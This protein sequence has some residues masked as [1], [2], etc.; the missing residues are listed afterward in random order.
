MKILIYTDNH[1]CE[2]FSIVQKMGNKYTQ[3]LENQIKSINWVE[4]LARKNH[5]DMV[6]CAGD[7][8]DKP[9]LTQQEITALNDINWYPQAEHYFLVGNHESEENDLHYNS[10]EVLSSD[11]EGFWTIS[12]PYYEG[13]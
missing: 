8:F 11:R 4:D 5:Y 10:A 3:R 6:I 2:K 12:K 7:F 9:N 13:G 1:F